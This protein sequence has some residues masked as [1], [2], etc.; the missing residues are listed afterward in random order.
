MDVTLELPVHA[1]LITTGREL[2]VP[3]TLRYTSADPFAVHLD[4]PDHVSLSGEAVTWTF[5]R[6]LLEEGLGTA[7]G[8]GSVHIW[9]C[10]PFRTVV[11]LH[12]LEGVA[13]VWFDPGVLRRF[14]LRSYAVVEPAGEDLGTAVDEGIASLLGGV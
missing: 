10:G 12:A 9:P 6:S 14:L 11:E 5:A 2:P 3:V 13:M 4:F 8:I 1:R 7:A